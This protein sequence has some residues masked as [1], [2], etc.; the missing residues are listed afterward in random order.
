MSKLEAKDLKLLEELLNGKNKEL[1]SLLENSNLNFLQMSADP[2]IQELLANPEILK[3]L[4]DPKL[5]ELFNNA[6][7]STIL[8]D[9][10]IVDAMNSPL[11]SEFG[12][13]V[14][15][16]SYTLVIG[17]VAGLL[18]LAGIL[19]AVAYMQYSKSK[20]SPEQEEFLNAKTEEKFTDAKVL[21]EGKSD[22]NSLLAVINNEPQDSNT[23]PMTKKE[24]LEAAKPLI[25]N[26][27]KDQDLNIVKPEAKQKIVDALTKM[28]E[29]IINTINKGAETEEVKKIEVKKLTENFYKEVKKIIKEELIKDI[30]KPETTVELTEK[31]KSVEKGPEAAATR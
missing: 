30:R 25:E 26:I 8:K 31:A 9:P 20:F 1:L 7:L 23:K 13:A 24:Q 6:G 27:S 21:I 15:G 5:T 17:I 28:T 2:K 11:L 18:G 3:L 16:P 29:K 22:F 14:S 12:K 10:Q 19:G 4:Q